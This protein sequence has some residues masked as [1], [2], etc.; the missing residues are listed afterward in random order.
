MVEA[1]HI[2][3]EFLAGV[4]GA[5]T[6]HA[7]FICSLIN[8][9][10]REGRGADERFVTT[11]DQN[12]VAAFARKWD[13]P[14]RGIY[15]CVSTLAPNARRRAK[16][17]LAEL[18]CL[19]ADI[20]FRDLDASPDEVRR[21]LREAM[22]PPSVIT[23]T[24]HGLHPLWL[25]KEALAATPENIAEVERLLQRLT[26]LFGADPA[27]AECARL[28]RLPGTHNSKRG[29]WVEVATETFEP[30]RRYE[31]DDLRDWLELVPQPLLRR[32]AKGGNGQD[33]NPFEAAGR[34]RSAPPIDV[35][36]RLAG[37]RFQGTGETAIHLTQLA[38]SAALLNRGVPVE[39]VVATLLAATRTAAG[40]AGQCWNWAREE[41]DLRRMCAD[42]IKKHPELAPPQ[43]APAPEKPLLRSFALREI[44]PRRWLH[45]GHY[46][47]K[48][49]VMTSAPSG[50]GKTALV[51]A[52][53][54]EMVTGSGLLGFPPNEG[55]LRVA[56]WNAEDDD[57]EVERR[58][59]AACQRHRIKLEA[60]V[61]RLFLGSRFVDGRRLAKV[62]R[63]GRVVLDDALLAAVTKFVADN[64]IDCAIFDPLIA[65]HAVPEN[66]V[67][68]MAQV[69]AAFTRIAEAN[70]CCV[71]LVQ[72]TRKPPPGMAGAVTANDSRGSGVIV[73]LTRSVR[74][75]NRMAAA[76]AELPG[77]EPEERCLYL[78]VSR[79]KTNLVPPAK[80]TWVRLVSVDLPNGD[81][82]QA[83]ESWA[84]P[85]PEAG[86]T[87][88][89]ARWAREEVRGKSYRTSPRSPDWFGYA[90]AA[91]LK[92]RV[93]APGEQRDGDELSARQRVAAIIKSWERR[94]VLGREKRQGSDRH[95]HDFFVPGEDAD[96]NE[97]GG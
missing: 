72:H 76:E 18:N 4:F 7:V 64:Q 40:D 48:H 9:D 42:W 91:R 1:L 45:A 93:G 12:D 38:V 89:D 26:D 94:G 21:I 15:F 6:E 47:R 90:L 55:A 71:E 44:P 14:K 78:R 27:A 57:D 84:Y 34:A 81:K 16:D 2:G 39:E 24:G 28:L 50:F 83:A 75:L 36:A 70:D 53:V 68:A 69:M 77:I 3:A 52:N 58:I 96:G 10:A 49:V 73:D 61:G 41:R 20:D 92:L 17:T 22:C 74:I 82:V 97:E 95:S 29:E 30:G 56:Y 80:A 65:F 67:S 32:R 87:A 51:T 60:L 86:V 59:A 46:V 8:N 25:F 11:R 31:L 79:D 85:E 23:A 54:L 43:P 66:D 63:F 62:D 88:D 37:M 5:S 13:L 33:P 19:H 35:E